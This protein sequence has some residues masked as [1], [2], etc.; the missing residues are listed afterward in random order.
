MTRPDIAYAAQMVSPFVSAPRS[1][2]WNAF[3]HSCVIL[4]ALSILILPIGLLY[5][6]L[7]LYLFYYVLV[8]YLL[9]Y[10]SVFLHFEFDSLGLR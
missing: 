6:V 3:L 2:H 7:V 10:L 4:V 1:T 5:Y 8:L 9:Y